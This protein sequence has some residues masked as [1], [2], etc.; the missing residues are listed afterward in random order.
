MA[1]AG[2]AMLGISATTVQAGTYNPKIQLVLISI[3]AT[4]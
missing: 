4:M 2:A 3:K 1:L